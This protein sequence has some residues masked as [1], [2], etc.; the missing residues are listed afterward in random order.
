ML[1]GL[2]ILVAA[3]GLDHAALLPTKNLLA[4]GH[5]KGVNDNVIC[6]NASLVEGTQWDLGVYTQII[7]AGSGGRTDSPR[8]MD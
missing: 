2:G 3:E 6:P 7:M 8:T 5:R 1:D 4:T